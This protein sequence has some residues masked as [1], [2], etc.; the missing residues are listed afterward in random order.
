MLCELCS[1]APSSFHLA[2]FH[3]LQTWQLSALGQNKTLKRGER[4]KKE[5]RKSLWDGFLVRKN[6]LV[7]FHFSKKITEGSFVGLV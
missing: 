3:S 6:R 1:G 5:K 4:S 7:L 2:S